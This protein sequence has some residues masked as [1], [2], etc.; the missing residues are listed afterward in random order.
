MISGLKMLYFEPFGVFYRDFILLTCILRQPVRLVGF[1]DPRVAIRIAS[2]MALIVRAIIW[3]VVS[4]I[5]LIRINEAK[6]I[7]RIG[8]LIPIEGDLDLSAYIPT[9]KL[10][11]ETI[12]DDTTLPFKFTYTF[13]DS[14]VSSYV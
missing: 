2:D 1:I 5:F 9:M 6:D 11:L 14:M 3:V 10:A 12:E 7:Y 4:F 8:V 13:N